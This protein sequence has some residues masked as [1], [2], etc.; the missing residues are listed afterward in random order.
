M[1]DA[2]RDAGDEEVGRLLNFGG[3]QGAWDRCCTMAEEAGAGGF[4]ALDLALAFHNHAFFAMLVRRGEGRH[5]LGGEGAYAGTC[6]AEDAVV[7]S[8][9]MYP[10]AVLYN[11]PSEK[12]RRPRARAKRT[13]ACPTVSLSGIGR[14]LGRLWPA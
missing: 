13:T 6:A 1:A 9:V 12:V 11:N 8:G 3:N 7:I 2:L 14:P 10:V 4:V 5:D